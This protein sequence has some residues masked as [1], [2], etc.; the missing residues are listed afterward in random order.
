MNPFPG[1]GMLLGPEQF[2][3]GTG[4][5]GNPIPL[6]SR[7]DYLLWHR[8]IVTQ[9]QGQVWRSPEAVKVFVNFGKWV[10]KCYWC[11]EGMLTRPDWNLACCTEC[12]AFYEDDKLIFPSDRRI[13]EA[14]LARPSRANQHWDDQQTADDLLRE[15]EELHLR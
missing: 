4:P 14:L 6:R 1:H 7:A 11:H 2:T 9:R 3:L 5:T 15:N 13:V 12:G 8:I 10:A